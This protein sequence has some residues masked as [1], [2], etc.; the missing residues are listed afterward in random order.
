M[1]FRL[2][3]FGRRLLPIVYAVSV[4][5][6]TEPAAA[7]APHIFWASDPVKPGQTVQ[8]TGMGLAAVEE[9]EIARLN[10]QPEDTTGGPPEQA[11]VLAKSDSGL[12]FVLPQDLK[13]GVFSVTLRAGETVSNFQLNTPDIYWAQGDKGPAATSGGWLRLSGRNVAITDKA[14]VKLIASDGTESSLNVTSPDTWSASFPIPDVPSGSYRARLW[15]GTGN[16]SAW[17]DA[18]VIEIEPKPQTGRPVMELFSNQPDNSDHDDTARINASL[19]ALAR[20]GGGILLLRAGIYRVNG[21]LTIPDGVGL[22]GEARDLVA[23]MWKDTETPPQAMIQGG[24]NFSVEDLTINA[25]RHLHIIRGG[26]DEKS[27]QPN[28]ANITIARVT[29]RASSFL[30][31]IENDEAA[32]RLAAMRQ[33]TRTGVVALLLGGRNIV[34]EDNDVLSSMRPLV[35]VKPTGARVTGNTLHIGRRGWYGISAPDGVIFENNR[36]IGSDLQASGGGINTFGGSYARNVLIRN[37]RFETMYGWDRE[38]MTTDGPGGFYRGNLIPAG[39]R[40]VRIRLEGLGNLQER[41]WN[42]AGLFVLGGKGLGLVA[43]VISRDG[44]MVRLD[45]DIST[46]IDGDSLVTIVPMQENYLIVGNSFE[47]TGGAQ[48]FG[49][50]YKHVFAGNATTRASGLNATS[51]DYK[52]PQPNFYLQFLQNNIT[53]PAFR[54]SAGIGIVGRQFKDNATL[55]TLGIVIRENRL[56]SASTIQVDGRSATAPSVSNVLIEQNRIEVSD[57]GINIGNGV[58]DLVIRDNQIGN[59]KTPIKE[60]SR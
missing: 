44:D 31:H 47:D 9:V 58:E 24:S 3:S 13:S 33:N 41:D 25:D 10:D 34:V 50:G 29:I 60:P 1:R 7:D 17:R 55:L 53:G 56:R 6:M 49:T 51:L 21:T 2:P 12:S 57:I 38:A 27:G 20:R 16:A 15:N 23:L 30:R 43:H 37:N 11:E 14:L 8:V 40:T 45:R 4:L 54:G 26:I 28:G 35:L 46:T 48:V 22:K 5:G 52:H 32:K 39:G 59:V 19:Q 36:L 18:G 42:G